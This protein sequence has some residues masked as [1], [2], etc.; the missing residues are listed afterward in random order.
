MMKLITTLDDTAF[1]KLMSI[2]KNEG[3]RVVLRRVREILKICGLVP[4]SIN[5]CN[6]SSEYAQK[7]I[8]KNGDPTRTIKY[9]EKN[10]DLI[11]LEEGYLKGDIKNN[12]LTSLSDS[13]WKHI[14]EQKRSGGLTR[15]E[16]ILKDG[17][18]K[19]KTELQEVIGDIVK[20][21]QP[22]SDGYSKSFISTSGKSRILKVVVSKKGYIVTL[23]YR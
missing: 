10:S 19:N 11:W 3:D 5:K 22:A 17:I 20:T 7:I 9:I 21:G 8:N 23:T 15:Y 12:G 6:L 16:E 4:M 2:V 18:V 13:G 1:G 14:V